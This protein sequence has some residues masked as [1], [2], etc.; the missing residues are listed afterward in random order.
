MKAPGLV[1]SVDPGLRHCGVGVFEN[2]RLVRAALVKS[3]KATE[4]GPGAW[5][6][7]AEAVAGWLKV[8]GPVA[9]LVVEIPQIYPGA[10]KTV[11]AAD[12]IELAGVDG[13]LSFAIPAERFVGYRP[14]EWKGNKSKAEFAKKI[15][16]RMAPEEFEAMEP[17]P[18]FLRHNCIDAIGIG[19]KFL[20]RL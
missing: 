18:K 14:R 4:R 20:G 13:A 10:P 11:N 2:S 6:A 3:P 15:E 1:V 7:M 5:Y 9:V 12:L 8:S 19:L 16:E 17:C